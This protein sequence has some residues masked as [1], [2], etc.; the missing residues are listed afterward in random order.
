MAEIMQSK[1]TTRHNSAV[2]N[3]APRASLLARASHCG[4]SLLG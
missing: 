3:D 4:R 2:E 1:R